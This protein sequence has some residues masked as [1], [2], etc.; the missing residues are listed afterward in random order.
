[1]NQEKSE[2]DQDSEEVEPEVAEEDIGALKQSLAE[3]KERAEGYL[4][5]WQ[6]AQAD[7]I[8]Y[9]R[10]SEQEQGEI[11]KF[12]NASLMSSLLPILDDLER[13]FTSIPS[14]LARLTWADGIRLIE[15]KLQATLEAQGLS[16]IKALGEPF[17]PKFH[18][19][20]VHGKG[21]EGIVVEELQKGYKLHDKVIRPAMVVVGNGEKE[22]EEKKEE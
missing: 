7:F 4:A 9:K 8:N 18:E 2:K 19:A 10:R 20:A 17:D 13:A 6:R 12:A 22:T 3:E 1:M 14:Q 5:N 21:K 15:R 16:P 11:V